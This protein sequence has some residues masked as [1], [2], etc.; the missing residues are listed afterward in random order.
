MICFQFSYSTTTKGDTMLKKGRLIA[1]LLAASLVFSLAPTT[2]ASTDV[3]PE[4]SV[5]FVP[6]EFAEYSF[7]TGD[8]DELFAAYLN[9]LFYGNKTNKHQLRGT[10]STGD[11]LTG[12]N[13]IIYDYVKAAVAEIAEGWRSSTIIEVP[14]EDFGI[15]VDAELTA[16]DLGLEYLCD[17]NGGWNSAIGTA[18]LS[19]IHFDSSLLMNSLFADCPYDLY[20]AD[21]M[22]FPS[23]LG[24][25]TRIY[26]MDG[27][28]HYSVQYQRDFPVYIHVESRYQDSN[29]PQ[30]YA[31]DSTRI[32]IA[33]EAADYA[34]AIVDEAAGLDD[35][36]KLLYYK[37]RICDLVTYDDYASQHPNQEDRGPWNLLY[38]F[39]DDSSTNVVCEGYS[40]AFQYLCDLT[41][42]NDDS[43][44]AYS[45]TG[46][47]SGGTGGGGAHKWNIVHMD[48]GRNYIADIT[49]SD[50]GSW[51]SSGELF[52]KGMQGDVEN[53]YELDYTNPAKYIYFGYDDATR[54]IFSDDELTLSRLDY[55][56]SADD[57][58][59]MKGINLI[60]TDKVGMR[61]H[62]SLDDRY[63][64]DDDYIQFEYD[65]NT[66]KQYVADSSPSTEAGIDAN[67]RVVIFELP[68]T[69]SEMT[70]E[71]T[72]RMVV[73]NKSGTAQTYSVK[74]YAEVILDVNSQYSQEARDVAA[75]LLDYGTFSQ[76]YFNKDTDNLPVAAPDLAWDAV[77]DE[78]ELNAYT[79][80]LTNKGDDAGLSL[81][82]A[83]LILYSEISL[84]FTL[85]NATGGDLSNYTI[86]VVDNNNDPVTYSIEEDGTN[87]K[88]YIIID[89]IGPL[90][91]GKMYRLSVSE[92][93]T[94]IIDVSYGP[95][96]YCQSKIHL[97]G[98]SDRIKNLCKSIYKYYKAACAYKNA[99]P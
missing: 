5:G 1:C 57:A 2:K 34:Q 68:L 99:N 49:N 33:W 45:V 75:A 82:S 55:G 64:T 87:G 73:D 69:A 76:L 95:M 48:D 29:N 12:H 47:L 62:V 63:V 53:G 8:R 77:A 58:A 86:S 65:G 39:D 7:E 18:L 20:W 71:V 80:V 46:I 44:C 38:V 83:T 10:K 31:L 27:V 19:N 89:G 43:I 72:F 25:Y 88:Y 41:D 32:S 35:Y 36:D 22:G 94:T 60:L 52:L 23:R 93:G 81:I 61:I 85:N 28:Q 92:G 26:T 84:R 9:N 56:Q 70:K 96:S 51:G 59:E 50:D 42:F 11:R 78:A 40:E 67:H 30:G 98:A 4:E 97:D 14:I 79:Y 37:Q 21:G 13:K 17:G 90:E 16:E 91:L 6:A 74:H 24:Y 54:S 3:F 15:D 66:I